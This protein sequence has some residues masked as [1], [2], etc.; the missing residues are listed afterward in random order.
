M[1]QQQLTYLGSCDSGPRSPSD[2]HS[3]PQ[4][5]MQ[6]QTVYLFSYVPVQTIRTL[7]HCTYNVG[8]AVPDSLTGEMRNTKPGGAEMYVIHV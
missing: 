1:A 5:D 4:A 3:D 7:V 8:T 2:E 6:A